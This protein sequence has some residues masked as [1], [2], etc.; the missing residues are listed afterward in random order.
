[1]AQMRGYDN[2][3][4]QGNA[5]EQI[6]EGEDMMDQETNFESYDRQGFG[7]GSNPSYDSRPSKLTD[8]KD[9]QDRELIVEP[10]QQLEQNVYKKDFIKMMS[11]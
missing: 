11:D 3:P 1:M 10:P 4:E 8:S 7:V 9:S 5:S 6:S 2:L